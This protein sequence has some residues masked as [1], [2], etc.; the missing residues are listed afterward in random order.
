MRDK[1]KKFLVLGILVMLT[2]IAFQNMATN[3][4]DNEVNARNRSGWPPSHYEVN[5]LPRVNVVHIC[6]NTN[7]EYNFLAAI[8]MTVFHYNNTVYQSLLISDHFD[9]MPTRYVMDDWQTYIDEWDGVKQVNFIG[10]VPFHK[11]IYIKNLYNVSWNQTSSI[12][13][14]PVSIANQIALHD[15]EYSDVV[16]IAP[17][18]NILGNEDVE[19]ISNAA[20]I[21]SLYNAPLLFSNPSFLSPET[22][23]VIEDIDATHAILVEIGDSLSST[24]NSQ[25][26]S[27]GVQIKADLTKENCVVSTIRNL[28]DKSMLCAIA[29]NW[30][31]LPASLY[32]A[33]YGGY[34][35][36]LPKIIPKKA[37]DVMREIRI[38]A[39]KTKGEMMDM[40]DPIEDNLT[41]IAT[42]FYNWLNSIDGSDPDNLETVV[43]FHIQPKY[44]EFI[45]S[46]IPSHPGISKIMKAIKILFLE[47]LW[48][49]IKGF[50]PTFE[51]AICGDP[52]NLSSPGAVTARMPLDF[53][54]N[55]ALVNRGGMYRAII[56]AN[57]RPIHVTICHNS[58][59]CAHSKDTSFEE[60]DE[61]IPDKWGRNHIINELLGWPKAGWTEENKYFP[62]NDTLEDPP[63]LYPIWP[64]NPQEPCH[65][66][67]P[68]CDPGF[69]P[70]YYDAG[71]EAHFHSGALPNE[72]GKTHPAQE[73][74]D[75]IGFVEDVKRGSSLLYF[76]HHGGGYCMAVRKYD[77]GI[78]QD[79]SGEKYYGY[80]EPWGDSYWPDNDNTTNDG[81][82]GNY[83]YEEDNILYRFIEGY[84]GR[85]VH[86][87]EDD[88]DNTHG[89][90][91]MFHGC[92]MV[93]GKMNEIALRHGGTASF[94]MN[95]D[96][97]WT[98]SSEMC[99]MW[100]YLTTHNITIDNTTHEAWTIGEALTYSSARV[101]LLYT[102][103]K[104][105]Q[106]LCPKCSSDESC[107]FICF[108]DPMVQ[109]VQTYWQS[110]EPLEININYGGH[111]PDKSISFAKWTIMV[112]LDGDSSAVASREAKRILNEMKMIGS[113]D[114]L[115][116]MVLIDGCLCGDTRLYYVKKNILEKLEW[117]WESNMGNK[118][119]LKEFGKKVITEYPSKYCALILTSDH[120]SGWQGICWDKTSGNSLIT[121][122]D[123]SDV[124]REITN[125][126]SKKLDLIG[127]HTCLAGMTEVAYEISPY[128]NYMVASEEHM[129][130][131]DWPYIETLG[132]L[133]DDPNMMPRELAISIVDHFDA[134]IDPQHGFKTTLFAI[135]LEGM[136]EVGSAI[137]DLT[138]L[139]IEDI[140]DYKDKISSAWSNTRKYGK[141]YLHFFNFNYSYIDLYH[142]TKL[143]HD[144]VEIQE[145]KDA[146]REVMNMVSTLVI[147]VA[148][149]EGDNS[150]GMSIYFPSSRYD[151]NKSIWYD[152]IPSPYE[153]L[154]FA[155][156]TLWNEFLCNYLGIL[157]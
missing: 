104:E 106:V 23:N 81:S 85:P 105:S 146:A 68:G 22:L 61:V 10:N 30:Q 109:F 124:I 55:I 39:L 11:K 50:A 67:G 126:G 36:Y 33:R 89:M 90:I 18:L 12:T 16:I 31:N 121:M 122:P 1:I 48:K 134:E 49:P 45:P 38:A 8:P 129:R 4:V 83:Y 136:E 152:E 143:L 123:F 6:G 141:L 92:R 80:G 100:A 53:I 144:Q 150:Y 111:K 133:R 117:P 94:A 7:T 91:T 34:V 59:R 84:P 74:V 43:T 155:D 108:G 119:T 73:D 66:G 86:N 140:N 99:C 40:P 21:A 42:V 78:A 110:P 29:E 113:S 120:G 69:F 130:W 47:F 116:L 51:Y 28:A 76:S 9:D 60:F 20:I 46:G 154:L 52:A 98:G 149:V 135:D 62:W 131:E 32:G 139:L 63:I 114:E 75:L 54:G 138:S 148:H 156:D 77:N 147:A 70:S 125:D 41:E 58:Y 44:F 107:Q 17:Y 57:P 65:G 112:Y 64:E 142:F 25:L 103:D 26:I 27:N 96:C 56:F 153:E 95:T 128:T 71:Y 15:W 115:N 102:R 101:A 93:R 79:T 97:S 87:L 14:D 5:F 13:G 137:D 72:T 2:G 3:I 35:F 37:N 145:V 157:H 82:E 132:E 19:S 151:Y 127:F 88:L 118:Q 24:V